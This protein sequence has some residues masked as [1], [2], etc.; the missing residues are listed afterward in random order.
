MH[1]NHA[2]ESRGEARLPGRIVVHLRRD[3]PLGLLDLAVIVP[4]YLGPLVLRFDGD[5]P[6]RY[7][8][9]FWWFV[10]VAAVLHLL[11]NYLFGLYGQMWRYASVQEARRVV[12]SGVT[13]GALIVGAGELWGGLRPL[14]LSVMILGA[15]LALMAFGAIRFQSRLFAFRRRSAGG[16]VRRARVLLVGAG[17]AGAMILRDILGNRSLGLDPVGIVD[18]DLRKRGLYMHGISVLGTPAA[19][20]PLVARLNVEQ[21]LLAIP[22]ATGE[23]VREVAALCEK[24]NVTLRVLPSVREIVGGKITARDIRDLRIED[25]LGRQQVQTDLNEVGAILRGR[26]VLVTGAG[27]SIGSEIARQVASFQPTSLILLDHDETHLH[28]VLMELGDGEHVE[29]VLADIREREQILSTFMRHRPEV[30]FHAAAHKHVPLLETY[31]QEAVLTNVIGTANVADAALAAGVHRFV[32]IS[33]D[34]AVRPASVMGATKWFAEQIVR[35]TRESGCLFCAVRFGNVLGSR[36]S[37]IPTFFR[38][39]ARG[40]PVTVTDPGM[41]RYFMSNQEAVQLVLQAAALSR[42]GEVLTL[43]M[44]EPVNI[45]ELA[46]R[47]IRLSG[48]V[49]DVDVRVEIT[50]PRPGEK[51]VEELIDP[52]EE[53]LPSG[54][55]GI[56]VSRPPVP[57][58]PALRRALRELEALAATGDSPALAE[59]MKALAGRS[60]QPLQA[61]GG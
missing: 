59:R 37:V 36:G 61:G 12:L 27:G 41:S 1:R 46:R 16:P 35:C 54:H 40:G 19:I 47:L 14:P 11:M 17:D 57:D 48:R 29:V 3:V 7:W 38:Q 10:A 30:V 23:V 34:K 50:G 18:D 56:A 25:L 20:P 55:P 43:D 39:I 8:D 58:R 15:V 44:G 53:Q 60:L 6:R 32:M 45:L 51:L 5:V 9:N 24:A 28:D 49:P 4:A 33:T 13:A 21:V 26:R 52:E 22:S 31:P 2:V 42:G